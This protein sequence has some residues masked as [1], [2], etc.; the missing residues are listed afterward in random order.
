[1]SQP[2]FY[3]PPS[4]RFRSTGYATTP[5]SVGAK[6]A[7]DQKNARRYP[8]GS[9]SNGRP[10]VNNS[11]LSTNNVPARAAG[12]QRKLELDHQ[13]KPESNHKLTKENAMNQ[14]WSRLPPAPV[15]SKGNNYLA[16]KE[17]IP[18]GGAPDIAEKL[19]QLSM[20][21]TTN[22]APIVPSDRFADLKGTTRAHQPEPVR[23]PV[24][25]GP[26]DTW[27]AR[28][29]PFRRTYEMP[30]ERALLQRKLV[31]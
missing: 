2:C 8:V 31:S 10:A 19:S 5:P 4:L 24:P 12:V 25:L 28:N 26:R 22:R 21:S 6:G 20:A 18:R 23:R 11:Y 9:L 3:V 7:M 30:G 15:R 13:V 27:H 17:Q 16:A 29:D 14:P 1:M